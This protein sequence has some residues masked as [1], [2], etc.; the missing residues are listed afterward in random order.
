MGL[1][2]HPQ[3]NDA[4]NLFFFDVSLKERKVGLNE[5]RLR[6]WVIRLGLPDD[7]IDRLL[8]PAGRLRVS[9]SPFQFHSEPV[10]VPD[11]P[12]S[13]QAVAWWDV[14]RNLISIFRVLPGGRLGEGTRLQLSPPDG[15]PSREATGVFFSSRLFRVGPGGQLIFPHHVVFLHPPAPT[16][17]P[18]SPQKGKDTVETY[19][20][21]GAGRL[22]T[23]V[24]ASGKKVIMFEADQ[25]EVE[26]NGGIVRVY[27]NGKLIG[28]RNRSEIWS[29][30]VPD[31]SPSIFRW[32]PDGRWV[33]LNNQRN[34]PAIVIGNPDGPL[35]E[36]Q[37]PPVLT[38]HTPVIRAITTTSG[39]GILIAHTE[40]FTRFHPPDRWE[41]IPI[42]LSFN[43]VRRTRYC[44]L[45]AHNSSSP[46]S[47]IWVQKRKDGWVEAIRIQDHEIVDMHI[48]NG[49]KTVFHV[50]RVDGRGLPRGDITGLVFSEDGEPIDSVPIT[51]GRRAVP[52]SRTPAISEPIS[53]PESSRS[54]GTIKTALQSNFRPAF[55]RLTGSLRAPGG[56]MTETGEDN[57]NGM[58]ILLPKHHLSRE[59]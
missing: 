43:Y 45:F 51:S 17:V 11:A 14:Q 30:D 57:L 33:V 58:E 1:V 35:S 39:N 15:T 55:R 5:G 54:P 25:E 44:W 42:L 52:I 9:S 48:E 40:G 13:H 4:L 56:F 47:E 41:T 3:N 32:L 12:I 21:T 59:V 20:K 27:K 23:P 34:P 7:R 18:A 22:R 28:I 6:E 2:V 8:G 50:R 16:V 46:H 31:P 36:L 37:L 19:E 24:V 38:I 10:P 53:F 29:V 49:G 26:L